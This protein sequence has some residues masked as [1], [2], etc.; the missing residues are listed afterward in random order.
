[1]DNALLK[2]GL[3][4]AVEP[5]ISMKADHIIERGDDGWTF[6]TPDKSLVAQCEHTVVVTR[7]EPI[8]LTEVKE[9]LLTKKRFFYIL[10]K[11]S[12]T[13]ELF[14]IYVYNF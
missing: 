3:V 7:G 9:P 10:L 14:F 11:R 4:I 6:V 5:F 13:V 12:N 1:M 2:D 8:I